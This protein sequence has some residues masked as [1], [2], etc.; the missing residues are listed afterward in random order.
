MTLQISK[1]GLVD[2][3][4]RDFETAVKKH[5]AAKQFWLNWQA[6]VDAERNFPLQKPDRSSFENDADFEKAVL[7]FEETYA[8][9]HIPY[10]EP[11]APHA[12]I[13]ACVGSDGV[14]DFEIVDDMKE[15][16]T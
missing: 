3:L 4:I 8:H 16:A 9:L 7:A 10:P 15:S 13:A 1:K 2:A 12:L 11:V 14:P 6:F 5:A